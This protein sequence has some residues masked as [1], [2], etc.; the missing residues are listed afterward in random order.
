[1]DLSWN[2]LGENRIGSCM[3]NICNMIKNNKI[4]I[5]LDISNNDFSL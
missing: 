5:H 4:I 2:R 3:E 1:M